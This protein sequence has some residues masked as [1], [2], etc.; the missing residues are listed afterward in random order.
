MASNP[1]TSC[2][3]DVET[4]ADFIFVGSKITVDSGCSHEMKRCLLL[5]REAMTNR[6]N[7]LKSRDIILPT[8]IRIV[9]AMVFPVVT[10]GCENWTIK[11]AEHWRIHAFKL[12]CSRRFL[13][14]PWTARKWDQ[15]ILKEVIRWTDNKA[16]DPILRPPD[17]NSQLPEKHPDAGKNWGQEEKGVTE[18]KMV[19]SLTQWTWVWANSGRKWR[20]GK[21]G[22]PQFMGSQR[23][24]HDLVTKQKGNR[25]ALR[26][27]NVGQCS[28]TWLAAA[29]GTATLAW[30]GKGG[31]VLEPE[32]LATAS[33][34][35][36]ALGEI[37]SQPLPP[38]R[39]KTKERSTLCP[40]SG[41]PGYASASHWPHPN[42]RQ[43]LEEVYSTEKASRSQMKTII[44]M[45]DFPGSPV[46]KTP[47]F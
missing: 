35:D 1:I 25:G 17:V 42:C 40:F 29:G 12:W 14:V 38:S 6:D 32:R 28:T 44:Y 34:R 27:A 13:R 19:A 36:P 18:G 47:C 20:T 11:K 30:R 46:V 2:W 37:G 9:K 4:V 45:R 10:C 22:T 3:I 31:V 26:E 24:G 5:G 43:M 39:A 8:K 23:G 15:S 41:R 7:I 21:P 16:E 33:E